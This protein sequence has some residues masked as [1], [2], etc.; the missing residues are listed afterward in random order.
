M[1]WHG[2]TDDAESM[3]VVLQVKYHAILE[4]TPRRA[5]DLVRR[6]A[7]SNQPR[8]GVRK[9]ATLKRLN[10][11]GKVEGDSPLIA[12]RTAGAVLISC[13]PGGGADAIN[14]A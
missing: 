8:G 1:P 4:D 3:A 7:Q 14:R 6:F 13:S 5:E 12:P 10:V 11:C 2:E 9:C